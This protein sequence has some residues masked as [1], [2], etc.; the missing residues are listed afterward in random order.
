MSFLAKL[1]MEAN[2]CGAYT[3][4]NITG[5]PKFILGPRRPEKVLLPT[6]LQ[7][8]VGRHWAKEKDK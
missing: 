5:S 8:K 2:L 4:T 1:S 6:F 3:A 7:R